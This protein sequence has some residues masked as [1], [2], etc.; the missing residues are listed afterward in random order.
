MNARP[1]PHDLDAEAAIISAVMLDPGILDEV[2]TRV[3]PTH[4]Y[5][6]ANQMVFEAACSAY[7]AEGKVDYVL[8]ANR[9][10][11]DQRLEQAGGVPYLVQLTDATPHV[12]NVDSHVAIVRNSARKRALIAVMQAH[13]ARGYTLDTSSEWFEAV[14]RDVMEA[15]SDDATSDLRVFRDA[16][17]DAMALLADMSKDGGVTGVPTGITRLDT[18]TTGLHGGDLV[19]VAG[20]PGMGKTAF[21]IGTAQAAAQAGFGVALFSLEM[22]EEQLVLRTLCSDAKIDVGRVRA[23]MIRNEEWPKLANSLSALGPLPLWINDKPGI[24]L[25]ELR[26]HCR[27]LSRRIARGDAEVHAERGLKLVVVD[28]LQLMATSRSRNQTR[29]QS[30]SELTRGGKELAKEL[31]CAVMFLSQ[32][33]RS[34]EQRQDKHPQLADLRE[35]GAIEQDADTVIFIY[36]D[37]YYDKDSQHRGIV[38]LDVAKQRNGPT[39]RV[40]ARFTEEYT[41][42]DNLA[43]DDYDEDLWDDYEDG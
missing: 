25:Q 7:D 4:F 30:I 1:P 16:A 3:A 40:A 20:R 22:P 35:S 38:E 42:F 15:C 18:K 6:R 27:R 23:G 39:G 24:G 28:Y 10:R 11:A 31:D 14:E 43:D 33:N 34:V 17:K 26:G 2:R 8:V 32:L 19:V 37:E 36:R 12:G 5:S 9:L 29:E 21:V 13:V 41:R